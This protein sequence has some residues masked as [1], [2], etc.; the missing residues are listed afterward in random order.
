MVN[1]KPNLSSKRDFSFLNKILY[2][3]LIYFSILNHFAFG[4]N[5]VRFEHISLEQGLSQSTVFSITQDKQGFMWF[6]TRDGLNKYD[7]S[8]F[9][10]YRPIANDSNSIADLGIRRI[11]TDSHGFIWI[12][13]LSGKVDR[14]DPFHDQFVHYSTD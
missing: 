3:L 12:I 9:T 7:G 10:I 4:A 8:R 2:L 5:Q 13:T 6:A 14:Y 11:I 1:L